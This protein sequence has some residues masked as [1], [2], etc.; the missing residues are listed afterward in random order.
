MND[1]IK[2]HWDKSADGYSKYVNYGMRSKRRHVWKDVLAREIGRYKVKV[3]DVGTGP[4][5]LALILAELGYD[6]IGLD[7]SE[8]ML[9]CG[10]ENA[11]RFDLNVNFVQGDAEKLQFDDESFDVVAS[12]ALL[13]TL[14]QPEKALR[15][16]KRV[17]KPMGKIVIID[18]SWHSNR[19]R[20]LRK[21]WRLLSLPLIAITERRTSALTHY[22]QKMLSQLPLVNKDRPSYDT[23]LLRSLGFKDIRARAMSRKDEGLI[24][25]LKYGCWG[26]SFLVSGLKSRSIPATEGERCED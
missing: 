11:I 21:P 26:D 5:T 23:D 10:R 7:A 13:W 22:N 19:K 9:K 17:L 3:L 6:V 14:P 2:E 12:R 4:G 18:G 15:E 20:Y 24:E 16:W 1:R 25:F 8:E